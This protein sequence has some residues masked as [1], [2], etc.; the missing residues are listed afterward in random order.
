VAETLATVAAARGEAP[1]AVER[2]VAAGAEE[3]FGRRWG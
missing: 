1:E 3:L 2:A